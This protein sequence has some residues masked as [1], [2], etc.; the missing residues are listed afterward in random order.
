MLRGCTVTRRSEWKAHPAPTHVFHHHRA[1]GL[2]ESLCPEVPLPEEVGCT[3]AVARISIKASGT[4]RRVTWT[5]VL[6]TSIE[7]EYASGLRVELLPPAAP[8]LS[9]WAVLCGASVLWAW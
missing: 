8:S 6:A 1:F 9:V 2:G 5:I 3:L 4:A 7:P